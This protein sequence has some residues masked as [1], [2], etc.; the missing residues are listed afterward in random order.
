MKIRYSKEEK[1]EI[2]IKLRALA[3][4]MAEFWDTLR[5]VENAHKCSI[6][7]GTELYGVLAGECNTPPSFTDLTD[8]QV[9]AM[10]QV[11][12]QVSK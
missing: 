7:N 11:Y 5:E 10:F 1:Q 3:V 9:W 12:A 4:S 8:K 2:I 6:D